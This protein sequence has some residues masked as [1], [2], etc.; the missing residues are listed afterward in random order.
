[1]V[2][3]IVKSVKDGPNLIVVDKK[4]QVALCRCGHSKSK[5]LCD[6]CHHAAKFEAEEKDTKI[7]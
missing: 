5:P 7:L 6:G 4:V 1:M 3:V 2:E